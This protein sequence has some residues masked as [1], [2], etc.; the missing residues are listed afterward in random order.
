MYFTALRDNLRINLFLIFANYCNV[1]K[2]AAEFFNTIDAGP[3]ANDQNPNT[4]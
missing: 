2:C 4:L 3:R 1:Q